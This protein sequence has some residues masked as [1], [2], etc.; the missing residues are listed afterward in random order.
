[1]S[2]NP[3][4]LENA[5]Q[6]LLAGA[7]PM[8]WPERQALAAQVGQTLRAARPPEI[9]LS[10]VRLLHIL[11]AD[12]KWEVRQAVADSLMHLRSDDFDP[13]IS[14]LASDSNAWVRKAAERTLG[15]RKRL[16]RVEA[17]KQQK[18]EGVYEDYDWFVNKY[19]HTAA[20]RALRIGERYFEI[21]ASAAT[22]EIRGVLTSLAGAL[23]QAAKSGLSQDGQLDQLSK[24]RERAAFLN[25]ILDDLKGYAQD[26]SCDF[27]REN[28][29]DIV[30]A[31][32]E[33][34]NDK[35]KTSA[36]SLRAIQLHREVPDHIALDACRHQ[37]VQA[38]ANV[39]QNA[40]EAVDRDGRVTVAAALAEN[41]CVAIRVTDNGVGM[42][43]AEKRDAFIPFKTSKKNQ[44][45]TGF[46]LPIAKKIVQAH[47]GSITIESVEDQGTTVTVTLPL[48][49][50]DRLEE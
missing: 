8:P 28:L 23:D 6:R 20:E 12:D 32:F 26:L 5:L 9:I 50:Q 27:R 29:R 35:L 45:G 31:A 40:V 42:S 13:M 4:D 19:G 46:G 22:H 47:G 49:Q 18:I 1:M 21:L 36:T 16:M 39:I 41:A 15:R 43:P 38:F 24:A 14:R 2:E 10:A 34:A 25:R 17:Q 11:S 37:L 3:S 48:T 30:E 33:L 44:G 7:P